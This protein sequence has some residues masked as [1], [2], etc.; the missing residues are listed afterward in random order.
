MANLPQIQLHIELLAALRKRQGEKIV[1]V[2]DAKLRKHRGKR[3]LASVQRAER[4]YLQ[5]QAD[6]VYLEALAVENEN[7]V[8]VQLDKEQL[9][10]QLQKLNNEAFARKLQVVSDFLAHALLVSEADVTR[11]NE[12]NIVVERAHREHL[13]VELLRP[14]FD[15][16]EARNALH[17]QLLA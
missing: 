10:T 11:S 6:F 14:D 4:G 3:Q 5:L 16:L 2:N 7:G 12:S 15:L 8:V 1:Y 9:L 13:G 17:V